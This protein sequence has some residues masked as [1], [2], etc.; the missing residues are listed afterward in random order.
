MLPSRSRVRPKKINSTTQS[1][2]LSSAPILTNKSGSEPSSQNAPSE[3]SVDN[4][5]ATNNTLL[6]SRKRR[7]VSSNTLS[8][9]EPTD[10]QA[11]A[12]YSDSHPFNTASASIPGEHA[13]G[14]ESSA[15]ATS[16][17]YT[18]YTDESGYTWLY[19]TIYGQY[20]YYDAAQGNYVPYSYGDASA[21]TTS[22][23]EGAP[24]DAAVLADTAGASGSGEMN[25]SG[26]K[27]QNQQKKRRVVRMAGGQVW[28]DPQL[29]SWPTDDYRLFVGDLGPEVT[30]EM[31]EQA[32]GKFPSLQRTR[33]VCEKKTGKSQGYGFISFGDADDFL[34]AWKE[35]NG[36]YVGSRPIKLRKSTWKSRNADIRKV[37][38]QDKR[39]FLEY[40][41]SKR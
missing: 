25:S 14:H 22:A 40:K 3:K 17:Q 41:Q 26:S 1:V 5:Y 15:G 30:S 4:T 7:D 27:S 12:Q 28:E 13:I 24:H 10:R 36:K 18:Y 6:T 33:V 11:Q 32:F 29:D 39:A 34:A 9:A 20:Y 31:L 21:T 16:E 19:D 23:F 37:K 38:R 35:F 2:V 8:N